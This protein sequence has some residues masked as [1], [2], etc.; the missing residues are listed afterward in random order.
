MKRRAP[1]GDTGSAAPRTDATV[2]A[3]LRDAR[4]LSRDTS[5]AY[6]LPALAAAHLQLPYWERR[7][8]GFAAAA[9]FALIHH[10]YELEHGQMSPVLN[11]IDIFFAVS[12]AVIEVT[13][14][15][16][17]PLRA[18]GA[19]VAASSWLYQKLGFAPGTPGQVYAHIGWHLVSSVVA[20]V[21]MAAGL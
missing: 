3:L 11:R 6:L 4:Q 8:A 13:A 18:V 19:V 21:L 9:I 15:P 10:A 20:A 2:E 14:V 1:A 7:C 17:T 5:L 12:A 16:P